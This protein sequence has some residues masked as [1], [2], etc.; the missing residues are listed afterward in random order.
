ML[1]FMILLN[2]HQIN[3]PREPIYNDLDVVEVFTLQLC[4]WLFR[5][6]GITG[7]QIAD[8]IDF[9][10]LLQDLGCQSVDS[11]FAWMTDEDIEEDKE[12]I[13]NHYE[14]LNP[15]FK[16]IIFSELARKERAREK[17]RKKFIPDP[18]AKA[19]REA[20]LRKF[21]DMVS[22]WRRK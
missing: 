19:T 10:S 3:D 7:E 8:F 17:S 1:Y 9:L 5:G 20:K 2:N 15:R 12:T 6:E 13:I 14:K 16:E 11:R 21:I 18:M 4:Q 22:G